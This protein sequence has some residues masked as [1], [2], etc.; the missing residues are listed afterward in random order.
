MKFI[1]IMQLCSALSNTCEE[2]YR[3]AIEFGNFYNCGIGG[4]SIAM[5]TIKKMNVDKV[6][7]NKLYV[8]FGCIEKNVEEEDA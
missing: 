8:R 4:Y 1:L 7:K 6:N 2:P 5:S 3:P